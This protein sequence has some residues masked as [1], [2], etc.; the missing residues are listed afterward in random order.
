MRIV[1]RKTFLGM[2]P[3]TIYCKGGRWSFGGLTIKGDSASYSNDWT[4]LEPGEID[5]E[6]SGELLD[7]W[8]EMLSTGKSYPM[9]EEAWRRDGLYEDDAIFLIFELS[10]IVK[11]R[12]FLTSQI[13]APRQG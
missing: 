8:E 3:G 12:N 13:M 10:D 5:A 1:D 6:D 7:R 9:D 2:P 4:Y 11:V